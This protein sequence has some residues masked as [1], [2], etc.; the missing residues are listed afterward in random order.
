M[1]NCGR[2]ANSDECIFTR[3]E[4]CLFDGVVWIHRGAKDNASAASY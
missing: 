2:Q 1:R 3:P 4:Y